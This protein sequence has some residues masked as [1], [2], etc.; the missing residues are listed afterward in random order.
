MLN[1]WDFEAHKRGKQVILAIAGVATKAIL[2]T[3]LF[4]DD[5]NG[6]LLVQAAMFICQDLL[7]IERVFKEDE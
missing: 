1:F 3:Q 2:A 7:F 5:E 6:E 4:T